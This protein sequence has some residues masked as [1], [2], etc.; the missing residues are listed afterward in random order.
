MY[1]QTNPSIQRKQPHISHGGGNRF[2][3]MRYFVEVTKTNKTN[4]SN[5]SPTKR[6]P[7]D[8]APIHL[9]DRWIKKPTL[10]G[11]AQS[12]HHLCHLPTFL[13]IHGEKRFE[14]RYV[15]GPKALISFDASIMSS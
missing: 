10:V 15:G 8:V 7:L 9:L 4:H 3:D 5:T 14:V 1:H 12:L 11:D 13:S 2:I 6:P